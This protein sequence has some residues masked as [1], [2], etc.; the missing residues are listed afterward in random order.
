MMTVNSISDNG[1]FSPNKT[2]MPAAS[3]DGVKCVSVLCTILP[4]SIASVTKAVRGERTW[5]LWE[6]TQS[7][8]HC[9]GRAM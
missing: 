6:M 5:H 3:R 4:L 1:Y 9:Q 2:R 7:L 8:L